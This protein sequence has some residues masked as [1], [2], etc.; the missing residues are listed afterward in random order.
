MQNLGFGCKKLAISYFTH[1]LSRIRI[2]C[3]NTQHYKLIILIL[4]L[5]IFTVRDIKTI[6][7][8]IGEGVEALGKQNKHFVKTAGGGRSFVYSFQ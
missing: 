1:S 8:P 5:M 3:A 6:F 4:I 2:V 7:V